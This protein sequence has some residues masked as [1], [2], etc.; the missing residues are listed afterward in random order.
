[1]VKRRRIII[2]LLELTIV[3]AI[4][5]YA[6]FPRTLEQATKHVYDRGSVT[7]VEVEMTAANAAAE[8]EPHTL[9]LTPDTPECDG[10]LNLLER[11][12]TP[13]YL[14]ADWEES[15]HSYT[16]VITLTT[17]GGEECA[18]SFTENDPIRITSTRLDRPKT[19][20][21]WNGTFQGETLGYLLDLEKELTTND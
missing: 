21:I 10:L 17:D 1:M 3:A 20:R 6:L 7:A 4:L 19:Y 14:G 11:R 15:V 5:I 16:V 18:V 2:A 8:A 12:Y 13:Y 9:S